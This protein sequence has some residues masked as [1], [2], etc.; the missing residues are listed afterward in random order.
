MLGVLYSGFLGWY[1]HSV[2]SR[3]TAEEMYCE[4]KFAALIVR[5]VWCELQVIVFW[6]FEKIFTV[7]EAKTQKFSQISLADKKRA[8]SLWQKLTHTFRRELLLSRA[9]YT[10]V[11]LIKSPNS[12]C[13]TIFVNLPT[14]V[15]RC[16]HLTLNHYQTII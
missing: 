2:V 12:V 16:W 15:N 13:G 10:W 8:I 1:L 7:A 6:W 4:I 5:W 14:K 11:F 9:K 3:G